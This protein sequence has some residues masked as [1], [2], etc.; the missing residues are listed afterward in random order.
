[1]ADETVF[2]VDDDADA[3]DSLCA[4]LE[5]AGVASEA[6]ESARERHREEVREHGRRKPTLRSFR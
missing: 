4:L 3:R 6:H 2:V 1:M 5:S